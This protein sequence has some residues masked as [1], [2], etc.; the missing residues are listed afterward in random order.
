MNNTNLTLGSLFSG[1]GGF[2]L[3]GKLAGIEPIWNSEIDPYC[4]LVTRKRLPE[5]KHYGD[6]CKLNGKEL[7]P[8]DIIT[9]GSPCQDLSI[10]G[11]RAGIID[12]TRSNLFFEAIRIIKEMR[13]A[14]EGIYPRYAVW[15]NVCGAFS[16]NKGD[17]F[18]EVLRAFCT[19][20]NA[21]ISVPR[22]EGKWLCA[23]EIMGDDFSVAWRTL[24]SE[25]WGVPQRR[26]RIFLVADFAGTSAGKILFES[27]SVPRNITQSGYPWQNTPTDIKDG[28]RATGKRLCLNDQGGQRLDIT[29]DMTATLRAK[30]NHPPIVFENHSADTRYTGPL[31]VSP[32]IGASLGTGGNNQP[33]V[34]EPV[35]SLQRE[36]FNSGAKAN[37]NFSIN[38]EISPTLAASGPHAVAEHHAYDVRF[39]SEGTKNWRA[40]VYKTDT[41]RTLDTG[42]C[43]P[44]CNQGGVAVVTYSTSKN[45]HHTVAEKNM[46]NTL[47]ASDYKDPPTVTCEPYYIVRRLTPTE[48]GRL[49]G[50]KD[51]WCDDLAIEDPSVDEIAFWKKV[52][53]EF[54]KPK[55]EKQIRK[56]LKNPCSDSKA[57]SMWGNGLALPCPYYVLSGIVYYSQLPDFLF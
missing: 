31:D 9:F 46:A 13:A 11:K 55:T 5:V 17:D 54:G 25:Y 22:F 3:S 7:E 40:N 30:S 4:T 18:Y 26:R 43:P 44:E 2:E 45:S 8:V 12:G 6:V 48:C 32:T 20:K 14:T 56:W 53:E 49:Q 51:D 57:Y 47:V 27:E 21:E 38:E 35:Y 39:T 42:G 23:G 50:F 19:V 28:F 52:Y 16:S 15:E 37:F 41:A 34:A 36:S 1:S 24:D 33:F 10:A 29:E